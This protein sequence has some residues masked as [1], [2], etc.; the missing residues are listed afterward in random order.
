L[1]QIKGVIAPE[2]D[3]QLLGLVGQGPVLPPALGQWLA[4]RHPASRLLLLALQQRLIRQHA[5]GG[6]QGRIVQQSQLMSKAQRL[7]QHSLGGI[8]VAPIIVQ[9]GQ[10]VGRHQ[11]KMVLACAAGPGKEIIQ[12][13]LG[14][15]RIAVE[16]GADGQCQTLGGLPGRW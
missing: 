15:L 10:P 4:L 6:I 1:A 2:L 3:H 16:Q 14:Q 11:F 12:G 7:L 13:G 8:P 5:I 9:L